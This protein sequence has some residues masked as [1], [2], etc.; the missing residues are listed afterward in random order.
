M[1]TKDFQMPD[2]I[3]GS[4]ISLSRVEANNKEVVQNICDV[5]YSG[6]TLKRIR[7]TMN[8]FSETPDDVPSLISALNSTFQKGGF[9]YFIFKNNE[10]IG[11][12]FGRP[13][14]GSSGMITSIWGWIS[15]NALRQGYMK[16]AVKMIENEYF[17]QNLD[18]LEIYVRTNSVVD[19]FAKAVHFQA[20][21]TDAVRSYYRYREDWLAEQQMKR[22]CSSEKGNIT[23]NINT[24]GM[25]R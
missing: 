10:A 12:I 18:P 17:T 11:Q 7:K 5:L 14:L 21:S 13:F 22:I 3:V 16:K 24:Q 25:S 20:Q 8:Y 4:K 19:S 23:H 6:E 15:D 9:N 2:E 1:I